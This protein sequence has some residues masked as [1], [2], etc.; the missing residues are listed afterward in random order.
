[1]WDKCFQMDN[2]SVPPICIED[3][4]QRMTYS[5]NKQIKKNSLSYIF[6]FSILLFM[7]YLLQMTIDILQLRHCHISHG[8]IN[9]FPFFE[10]L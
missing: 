4:V 9:C 5:N 10:F 6:V 3:S 8:V 1:M 7:F 2:A